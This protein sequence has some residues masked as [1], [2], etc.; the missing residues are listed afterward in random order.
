MSRA[1]AGVCVCACVCPADGIDVSS[2]RALPPAAQ[3]RVGAHSPQ[4]PESRGEE[5]PKSGTQ[6]CPE[7]SPSSGTRFPSDEAPGVIP[8]RPRAHLGC[9]FLRN[10]TLGPLGHRP[11]APR[12]SACRPPLAV[13]SLDPSRQRPLHGVLLPASQWQLRDPDLPVWAPGENRC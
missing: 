8:D 10:K 9:S 12:V 3:R 13:Q 4:A 11:R 2:P 7:P 6:V 1:G 5:I